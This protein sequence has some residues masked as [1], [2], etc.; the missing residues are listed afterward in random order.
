MRVV[1]QPHTDDP[2]E[3]GFVEPALDML[4]AKFWSMLV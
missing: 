4:T 1:Y 3:I 2:Q